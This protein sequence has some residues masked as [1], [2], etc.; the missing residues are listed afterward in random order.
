MNVTLWVLQ[1]L[2]ALH[3]LMGAIWKFSHSPRDTMPSLEA[4]PS[5]AWLAMSFVEIL[6]ALALV[7]PA[8]QRRLAS[9]VP[10][11]AAFLVAEMLLYSGLHLASGHRDFGPVAYWL[12]MAAL[13]AVVGLGRRAVR[14]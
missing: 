9:L 14:P 8:F 13:A 4:I 11:A 1:G 5:G 7:V 6:C 3:T 10:V 2:L 12:V